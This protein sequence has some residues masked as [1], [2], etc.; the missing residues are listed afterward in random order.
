MFVTL[1]F[2]VYIAKAVNSIDVTSSE[3]VNVLNSTKM[4]RIMKIVD[5]VN[6][7]LIFFSLFYYS[8]LTAPN[9]RKISAFFIKVSNE[10]MNLMF[11]FLFMLFVFAV[12]FH[13]FYEKNIWPLSD[14]SNSFISTMNLSMGNQFSN[15]DDDLIQELGAF[16]YYMVEYIDEVLD[17]GVHMDVHDNVG[18]DICDHGE[19]VPQP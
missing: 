19:R 2:R 13:S 11:L 17:S 10:M 9:L 18:V 8:S 15:E 16:Y 14:F 7:I 12:L 1:I 3:Y 6:T 4:L 5:G